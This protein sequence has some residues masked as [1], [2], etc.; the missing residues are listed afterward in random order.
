[1]TR[2]H[3]RGWA[4]CGGIVAAVVVVAG[5]G[6]H[7][8]SLLLE[9]QARGPLAEEQ[10]IAKADHWT[11]DPATQT[12]TEQG[13]EVTLAYAS[14]EFLNQFFARK[15]VFGGYAGLD[16]YFTEQMVFYVKIAN[17][18]GKK[19]KID[20]A[21]FVML[22]DKGNQYQCIGPDYA[23]ALADSKQ[24]V[25]VLT[26]GVID[27]ARP[28][29]FGVGVPVG[30]LMGKPQRRFALLAMSTLQ[31]GYLH[32]GVVYDGLVSFWSPNR[33]AQK[34]KLVMPNVKTDFGA[35]DLPK[36]VIELT[37]EMTATHK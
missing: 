6:S 13:V 26:R 33:F 36:S 28:G 12:K 19:I 22:D 14:P 30:K 29:Y 8:S 20:P 9:R 18:S 27:D 21:E 16:P 32:D 24:P 23:N 2:E 1:M 5:C 10:A 15:D 37:F 11:L 4:V 3:L 17:R 34:V 31:G 7:K 35:D 25:G